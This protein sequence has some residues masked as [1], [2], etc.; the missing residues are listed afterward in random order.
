LKEKLSEHGLEF[1]NTS[2]KESK[3]HFDDEEK[4]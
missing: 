1:E 2:N 4:E 3:F